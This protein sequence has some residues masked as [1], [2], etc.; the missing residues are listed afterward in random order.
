MDLHVPVPPAPHMRSFQPT[1]PVSLPISHTKRNSIYFLV[2]LKRGPGAPF[3]TS[4]PLIPSLS[5][6][7]APS[8][9]LASWQPGHKKCKLTLGRLSHFEFVHN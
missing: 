2:M 4:K 9:Q 8:E 7:G 6:F 3:P 5:V 1:P